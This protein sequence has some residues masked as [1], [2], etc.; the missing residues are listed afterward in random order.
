MY[1]S[2]ILGYVHFS[3]AATIAL[4]PSLKIDR[5][6]HRQ[7]EPHKWTEMVV[8]KKVRDLMRILACTRKKVLCSMRLMYANVCYANWPQLLRR[9]CYCI[10][11]RLLWY[12]H[13]CSND[14][15]NLTENGFNAVIRK[16]VLPDVAPRSKR[17]GPKKRYL[18]SA[19]T[20]HP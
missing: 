18:T 2:P 4:S 15:G 14:F 10:A 8:Q 1:L 19:E 3:A 12:W 7:K 17:N 16:S 13:F 11:Y 5:S 9:G 20:R 6:V